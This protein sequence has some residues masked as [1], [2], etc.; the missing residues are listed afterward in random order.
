MFPG[1]IGSVKYVSLDL[2]ADRGAAKSADKKAG[3]FAGL[4]AFQ[5]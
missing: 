3:E 2:S 5:D 1:F 4:P